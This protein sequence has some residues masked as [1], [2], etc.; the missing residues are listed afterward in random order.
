MNCIYC[1]T[2]IRGKPYV[3]GPKYMGMTYCGN[4]CWVRNCIKI[5][6]GTS[7][8]KGLE[9]SYFKVFNEQF[10]IEG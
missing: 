9:E 5:H 10:R 7:L 3:V 4:K 8:A 2:E 1:G 6:P